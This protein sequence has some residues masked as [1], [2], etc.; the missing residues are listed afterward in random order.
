MT[1]LN[2]L[3]PG[4]WLLLGVILGLLM[5]VALGYTMARKP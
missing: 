1:I 5:A 3:H 2:Q 4:H